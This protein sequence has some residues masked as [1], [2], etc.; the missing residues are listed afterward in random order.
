MGTETTP[1]HTQALLLLCGH[2]GGASSDVHPLTLREYNALAEWLHGREM[3]PEDLLDREGAEAA[4]AS[5]PVKDG[6][7]RLPALLGRGVALGFAV[8]G[9]ARE[10]IW[11]VGRGDER[12]PRPL[13]ARLSRGAPVLLF[14]VGS[15][16]N[17][18]A[19]A[20]GAV[21]SRDADLD[22]LR[23]TKALGSLCAESGWAIVSGA[24]RGVDQEAMMAAIESGGVAVGVLAEG[25][26]KPSRSK[27]FR[28]AV[29]DGALTL[30]STLT[31]DARW[32]AGQAMARNKLV[33][34]MSQATVVVSSGTDGGT[35]S[36]ATENL[37]HRWTPVWVRA[38]AGVPAGNAGLIAEGAH[39]LFG[40][41]LSCQSLFD[42]LVAVLRP[43]SGGAS[44]RQ[45]H[46]MHPPAAP[47]P[48]LFD[49]IRD[50]HPAPAAGVSGP[51]SVEEPSASEAPV[52]V[53]TDAFGAVWP[54]I[55]AALGEPR[56]EQEVADVL[57][58][59][60]AQA[61]VWL[62][63]AAEEGLTVRRSRPVR[64]ELP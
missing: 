33:Y 8:D 22:A 50:D 61:R 39:P 46:P 40:D 18:N 15:V 62:K 43:T 38:G 14:G 25:V 54:L 42:D 49:S 13:R 41:Q 53:S 9:W 21:G 36:G 31:P 64:Y 34:A 20:I 60:P 47:A 10:G 29:A 1:P 2:F 11:V 51:S 55:Q 12:Y 48:S 35:W 58:V 3:R 44:D 7:T 45:P 27:L 6:P 26:S 37:K 19:R 17:L 59:V 32:R 63:R 24:A 23:F 4:M 30:V 16:L 52:Q 28:R 56:T 5:G 57:C